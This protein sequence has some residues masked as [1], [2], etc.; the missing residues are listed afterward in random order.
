[1]AGKNFFT[2]KNKDIFYG[3]NCVESLYGEMS[4]FANNAMT[5]K[6]INT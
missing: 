2:I 4:S 3:Q 1:M 5:S 6:G